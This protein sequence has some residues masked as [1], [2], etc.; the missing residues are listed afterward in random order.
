MPAVQRAGRDTDVGWHRRHQA[1]NMVACQLTSLSVFCTLCSYTPCHL[2]LMS[3]NN[4]THDH[5]NSNLQLALTMP[6][7]RL[8]AVQASGSTACDLCKH[9]SVS[10]LT[11]YNARVK[12]RTEL[13]MLVLLQL[14]LNKGC[15]W[16]HARQRA[17]RG[18]Q[19]KTEL[20]RKLS[21]ADYGTLGD[22]GLMHARQYITPK[23]LHYIQT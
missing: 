4:Q 23:I 6:V 17:T 12:L 5:R 8:A 11:A 22:A 21:S 10:C 18:L 15:I 1:G 3:F 7:C 2:C 14:W 20:V 9:E 13:S 16:T 19:L